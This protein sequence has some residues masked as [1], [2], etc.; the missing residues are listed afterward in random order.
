M[1]ITRT[2]KS[3]QFSNQITTNEVVTYS[4]DPT[5]SA[6]G[7]PQAAQL[8]GVYRYDGN[9]GPLANYSFHG[10]ITLS[11]GAF[12]LDLTALPDAQLGTVSMAGKKLIHWEMVG[13]AANVNPI[14]AQQG[15][16][17]GF[18]GLNGTITVGPNDICAHG[19]INVPVTVASG[20]KTI[21]FSGTGAQQANILLLFQ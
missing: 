15:A 6:N 14:T 9:A 10:Q 4:G 8:G 3:V 13:V 12:T 21:D 17:N 1:T 11:S 2:L 19:P 7:Q 18:T 20:V 5:V 16:S